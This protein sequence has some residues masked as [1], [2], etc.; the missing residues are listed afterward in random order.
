[1]LPLAGERLNERFGLITLQ[2]DSQG[3]RLFRVPSALCA[4]L[5]GIPPT[6]V[7]QDLEKPRFAGQ[8]A[9]SVVCNGDSG[10]YFWGDAKAATWKKVSQGMAKYSSEGPAKL[11]PEKEV[12]QGF[13]G[14][15]TQLRNPETGKWA[16]RDKE[17][18]RIMEVKD[19]P[20]Q[21]VPREH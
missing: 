2:F 20:Y 13:W 11:P 8:I 9:T 16:K 19:E 21:A 3:P 7:W 5:R 15:R 17:T 6:L 18:G 1:M 4:I 10:G 12:V 14:N